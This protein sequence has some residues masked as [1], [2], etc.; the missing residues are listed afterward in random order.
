MLDLKISPVLFNFSN[1]DHKELE[2][3]QLDL[4]A[5]VIA[6]NILDNKPYSGFNAIL[7]T[8][9]DKFIIEVIKDK[10]I[11]ENKSIE[12][13][14]IDKILTIRIPDFYDKNISP[15]YFHNYSNLI[16]ND[17]QKILD[18]SII[19]NGEKFE[20]IVNNAMTSN[21]VQ[22]FI[23]EILRFLNEKMFKKI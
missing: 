21:I 7:K 3:F 12:F 9:Q 23:G 10:K 19:V 15:N 11:N 16:S 4:L 20:K 6:V 18:K 1:S 8:Y 17:L 13:N 2:V 22:N 5:F 14:K